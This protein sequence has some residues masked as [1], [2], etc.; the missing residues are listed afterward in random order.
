MEFKEVVANIIVAFS[1]AAITWFFARKKQA[2][3]VKTN[4]LDNVE[5]A[6]VIWRGIAE[7]LGK[8]VDML[9]AKCEVLSQEIDALRK[10]NQSLKANL[11]QINNN[12]TPT[13]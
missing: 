3:E 5:K 12:Y 6:I 11:R 13:K 2:A 4:E 9:T 7:D 1:T 10:E 8:K